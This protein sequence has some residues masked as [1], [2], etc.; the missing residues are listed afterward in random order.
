[1]RKCKLCEK[2]FFTTE[3]SGNGPYCAP[4]CEGFYEE[5]RFK[6][7]RA[8]GWERGMGL[9]KNLEQLRAQ[10]KATTN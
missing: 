4:P 5:E 9:L 2:H 3:N 6:A 7:R 1:M 10:R 8:P